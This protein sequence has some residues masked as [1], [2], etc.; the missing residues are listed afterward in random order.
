MRVQED[1]PRE[2]G[3]LHVADE[4]NPHPKAP[5]LRVVVAEP[6]KSLGLFRGSEGLPDAS[7]RAFH[8]VAAGGGHSRLIERG[9]YVWFMTSTLLFET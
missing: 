8:P 9:R 1:R 5:G 2:F 3:P 7:L 6:N 4:V